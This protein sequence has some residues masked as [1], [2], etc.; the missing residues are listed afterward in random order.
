MAFKTYPRTNK[1]SI[2][3]FSLAPASDQVA[4]GKASRISIDTSTTDGC[5]ELAKFASVFPRV[6]NEMLKPTAE[7]TVPNNAILPIVY[8]SFL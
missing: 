6:K 1:T 5:Q 8:H 2:S 4:A 3:N 7:I